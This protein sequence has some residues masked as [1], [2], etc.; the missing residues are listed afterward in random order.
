MGITIHYNGKTKDYET[1]KKV[2]EYAKLFAKALD[3]PYVE[4]D[5]KVGIVKEIVKMDKEYEFYNPYTYD[6]IKRWNLKP[7]ED[8]RRFG[9]II[10]L[11]PKFKTEDL[12]ITF[13][14]FRDEYILNDFCKTQA[15]NPNEINNLIAHQLIIL[16]LLT[17]KHTWIKDLEIIDEGDFYLPIDTEE[18]KKFAEGHINEEF[19]DEFMKR[20]PFNFETLAKN[21]FGLAQ[22]INLIASALAENGLNVKTPNWEIKRDKGDEG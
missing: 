9:I 18:R 14:K 4:V 1:A 2:I 12:A 15:F 5:E 8:S 7:I 11:F 16:L 10:K 6:I 3:I 20:E 22:F 13:Y 19:R 21:H 17:I